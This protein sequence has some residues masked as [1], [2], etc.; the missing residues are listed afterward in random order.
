M[1]RKD[2]MLLKTLQHDA[3]QRLEDLALQV[4]LAVSSV[5]ERLQRLQ[6]DGTIRRWTIEVDPTIAGL[7]VLAFVG[8]RSSRPCS[9]LMGELS[10]IPGIEECHSVAGDLSMLLKVRVP[11]TEDLLS[12]GDKLRQI[13]GIEQVETTIVLKTQLDRPISLDISE[14]IQPA[15]S[16]RSA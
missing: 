12:L 15:S 3:S 16:K 10:T 5:H 8:V 11:R 6:R 13:P 9:Q 2:F 1:D 14:G 4:K 7:H